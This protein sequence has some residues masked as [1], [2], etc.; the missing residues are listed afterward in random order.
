[1]FIIWT[2]ELTIEFLDLYEKEIAIWDPKDQLHRNRDIVFDSWKKI[3]DL[4]SIPVDTKELKKKKESLM[5]TFRPLLAKKKA[6]NKL[7]AGTDNVFKPSWFAY[8]KMETFLH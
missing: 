3:K 7:G 6:S 2:N 8:E 1:M 4:M 5:S